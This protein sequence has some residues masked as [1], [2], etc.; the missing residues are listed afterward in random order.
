MERHGSWL[1][2]RRRRRATASAVVQ[3]CGTGENEKT[4]R[5]TAFD[6]TSHTWTFLVGAKI[7]HGK[8]WI[9]HKSTVSK[10]K[11]TFISEFGTKINL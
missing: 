4:R 5:A 11:V 6:G 10:I 3:H 7:Y 2:L 8:L 1:W 9:R